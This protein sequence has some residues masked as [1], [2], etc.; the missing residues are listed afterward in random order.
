METIILVIFAL[1]MLGL[2]AVI[3]PFF[4]QLRRKH[5]F[6]F[7]VML[8]GAITQLVTGVML[9][10]LIEATGEGDLNYTKIAI[11][12]VFAVIVLVAVVLA[13]VQQRK[14]S[15]AGTSER[16]A[17]PWLHITGAAAIVNVFVAALWP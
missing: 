16:I 13:K 9:V 5:G 17:L 12:F 11:K 10:G 6:E 3:G 4:L 15:A 7:G 14:A 8:I 2:A 1:H